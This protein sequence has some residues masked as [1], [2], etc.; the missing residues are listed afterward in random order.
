MASRQRA[1]TVTPFL[2]EAGYPIQK[3]IFI[4]YE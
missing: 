2:M 3:G 4:K 1:G